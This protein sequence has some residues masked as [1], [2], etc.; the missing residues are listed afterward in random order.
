MPHPYDDQ[1]WQC[2]RC[3]DRHPLRS[4]MPLYLQHGRTLLCG[5]C[6]WR[7]ASSID[8]QLMTRQ[9]QR[10]DQERSQLAPKPVLVTV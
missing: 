2:S 4:S 9:Q 6:V 5:H 3:E 7:I 8:K 1:R 10:D